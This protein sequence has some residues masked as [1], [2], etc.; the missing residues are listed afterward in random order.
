MTK[1]PVH[2]FIGRVQV[3]SVRHDVHV[4]RGPFD[5]ATCRIEVF[6]SSS[7][8]TEAEREDVES[9]DLRALARLLIE[10]ADVADAADR[11]DELPVASA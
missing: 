2:K 3:G 4:T 1:K 8:G 6:K 11:A 5:G 9:V 10:A 7:H